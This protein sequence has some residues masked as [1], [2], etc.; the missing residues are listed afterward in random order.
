MIVS[1]LAGEDREKVA[2][3][4]EKENAINTSK[5]GRSKESQDNR[6]KWTI[7]KARKVSTKRRGRERDLMHDLNKS[8]A[9]VNLG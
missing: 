2:G 6:N 5:R 3:E 9:D 8:M 7:T 1:L 4:K